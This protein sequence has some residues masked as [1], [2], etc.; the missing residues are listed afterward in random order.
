MRE[1]RAMHNGKADRD[2]ITAGNWTNKKCILLSLVRNQPS[3]KGQN[4][5]VKLMSSSS[6]VL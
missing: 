2:V 4:P 5:S 1:Q 3:S 6:L